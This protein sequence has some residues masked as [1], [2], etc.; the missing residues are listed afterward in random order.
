MNELANFNSKSK[1][2]KKVVSDL[3][4]RINEN[5]IYIDRL[6]SLLKD[7]GIVLPD[8]ER[9]S[10][11]LY[12]DDAASKMKLKDGSREEVESL[13]KKMKELF[14]PLYVEVQ[15]K[16]LTFWKMASEPSIDTVGSTFK[17]LFNF[18]PKPK[19]RVDMLKDLTGRFAP[20]KMTLLLG[21]PGS[22]RTGIYYYT[23][24]SLSFFIYYFNL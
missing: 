24:F 9:F 14:R 13:L 12:A 8:R 2:Q 15:F 21:P 3:S 19:R 17:D 22:G 7:N 11:I 1:E 10:Q 18:V 5:K 20:F 6:E 23:I 4:S 16:N